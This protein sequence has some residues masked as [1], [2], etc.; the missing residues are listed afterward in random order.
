MTHYLSSRE[1]VF[2]LVAAFA[3]HVGL[4]ALALH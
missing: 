3:F 1:I 2:A 4:L